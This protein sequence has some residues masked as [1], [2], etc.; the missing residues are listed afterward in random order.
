MP[1]ELLPALLLALAVLL[2]LDSE[3]VLEAELPLALEELALEELTVA[4]EAALVE[5]LETVVAGVPAAWM[6]WTKIST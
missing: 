1:V 6:C 5:L 3:D 2:A 4:A